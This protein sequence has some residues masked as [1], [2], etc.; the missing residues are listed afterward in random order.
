MPKPI[1]IIGAGQAA[2]Q[3]V[4]SLRSGHYGGSITLIGA[5]P[6]R[7][8]QRPPLSKKFLA[9][10]F[11]LER[12]Y[13]KPIAFYAEANVQ[14]EFGV[15]VVSIDR[16]NR[17]VA[18]ADGR[19][20]EYE[21]LLI[22]TGGRP[23]KLN[24]PGADLPGVHYLRGIADAEAVRAHFRPGARLV[25]VG[26]GFIGLEIA[27]VATKMGLRVSLLESAGRVLA[28]VA[29]PVLSLFLERIHAEEGVEVVSGTDVIGFE[30]ERTVRAVLCRDGQRIAADFVIVGIGILP[31][32]ELAAD[33]GLA[34]DD[35]I[36]V[37]EFA[38]TSDPAV[39][40]AGDCTSY[41]NALYGRRVRLESV[42]NA[43]EQAKAAVATLLC[44]RQAYSQVPWFWSDQY[45]VKLQMAG[46]AVAGSQTVVR[47]ISERGR[48]FA[49]FQLSEG[50]LTAVEAVNRPLEFMAARAAIARRARPQPQRLA[51][52]STDIRTLAA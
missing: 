12:L 9:D 23:R 10:A 11:D 39:A 30:G 16:R 31:N 42:Q 50:V 35:G 34:V 49:L 27:A 33:A 52:D 43:I 3:A 25:V 13:L 47:G 8:Y 51:D 28:R 26:A 24:V 17:S 32:V 46:L 37:D 6:Y 21:K 19:I 7:P 15:P 36:V 5:E 40:A 48:S 1:V 14:C 41:P 20:C 18:L 22:A 44:R 4:Q 2:C 45:D 29:H 38:L